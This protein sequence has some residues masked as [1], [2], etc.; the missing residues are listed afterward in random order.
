VSGTC[1]AVRVPLGQP[2]FLHHLRTGRPALFGGFAGTTGLSDFPRSFISGLRPWPSLSGPS[3][4]QRR[5]SVG[6]PGSRAWRLRAC[7][8]FSDRAGSAGS[9]RIAPPAMLPSASGTASA[10]RTP[11][12]SRLNSPACTYPCQRF[13]CPRGRRRM[14]RGHRGSL[15]FDVERSHLLPPCRFI[16]ALCKLRNP[17][18]EQSVLR[19]CHDRLHELPGHVLAR[20]PA[21]G[22]SSASGRRRTRRT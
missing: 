11:L 7:T 20:S 8:W 5:A 22:P 3:R 12:I 6:S 21:P 17:P 13:A 14:T 2:P 9:S 16:P 10:P 15:P 1:F 19:T 18:S 4:D